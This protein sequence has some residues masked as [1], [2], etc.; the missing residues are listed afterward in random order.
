MTCD[1]PSATLR[2]KNILQANLHIKHILQ[3]TLRIGQT[4]QENLLIADIL[5]ATTLR[6][7]HTLRV[8]LFPLGRSLHHRLLALKKP[9]LKDMQEISSASRHEE[10]FDTDDTEAPERCARF[11]QNRYWS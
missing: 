6:T 3:A 4:L 7:K 11:A 10:N 2:D 8:N 9:E 5:Q 1:D